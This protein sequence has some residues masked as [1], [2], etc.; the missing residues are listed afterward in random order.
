MVLLELVYLSKSNLIT[1]PRRPRNI[2][3]PLNRTTISPILQ[4]NPDE[5]WG[6][7]EYLYPLFSMTLRYRT[8]NPL[9]VNITILNSIPMGGRDQA[10]LCVSLDNVASP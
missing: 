10:F 1:P 5:P 8:S 7:R 4:N 2:L 3:D 6:T 9:E